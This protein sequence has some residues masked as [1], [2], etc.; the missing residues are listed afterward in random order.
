[1]T[2]VEF[3][4]EELKKLHTKFSSSNI[5]YE[6][7]VYTSTHIVEITPLE[8][9][10]NEIYMSSELDLEELFINEYPKE[11]IIFVSTDSLNKVSNP[12][13]E[14]YCEKTGSFTAGFLISE[15][16]SFSKQCDNE[17]LVAGENNYAL[18]A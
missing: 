2:S 1:M 14:I 18:A 12:I 4:T 16:T 7:N 5:R 11:N 3:I 13:F 17:Y 6:F 10:N 9:Y 8:F 15:L